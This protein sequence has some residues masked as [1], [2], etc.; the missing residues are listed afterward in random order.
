M[1][2]LLE[3]LLLRPLDMASTTLCIDFPVFCGQ[4]T[5][6]A[7][8]PQA[9]QQAPV[10]TSSP[11]G[12][13]SLSQVDIDLSG[14][15]TKES[16]F[17]LPTERS[18]AT[19]RTSTPE[20][21]PTGLSPPIL[22]PAVVATSFSSVSFFSRAVEAYLLAIWTDVRTQILRSTTLSGSLPEAAYSSWSP[23]FVRLNKQDVEVAISEFSK[24][25]AEPSPLYV[26]ATM[27]ANSVTISGRPDTLSTFSER[28]TAHSS[29]A[30]I[31]VHKTTLDTLYHAPLHV[32]GTREEILAGVVR[33]DIQ[34]PQ[35]ADIHALKRD[36]TRSLVELIVDMVLSQPVNWDLVTLGVLKDLPNDAS[37]VMQRACKTARSYSI[38]REEPSKG[39]REDIAAVAMAVNMPGTPTSLSS[40]KCWN[41][42]LTQSIPEN[43]FKV[44]DYSEAKNPKRQ[45]KA[46]TGNF[47]EGA[48]GFDNHF[49]KIT[50]E[51]ADYVP[52]ATPS[53]NL[54]TFG[55]YIGVATHHYLQNLRDDIDVRFE[56]VLERIPVIFN[57]AQRSLYRCTIPCLISLHGVAPLDADNTIIDRVH[58]TW[59]PSH[60]GQTRMALLNDFGAAG[61]NNT[62]SRARPPASIAQQGVVLKS[63]DFEHQLV[64]MPRNTRIL[65][66]HGRLDQIIPFSFG[67]VR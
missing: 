49:F 6:V 66:V 55:C 23:V 16:I 29:A 39:K 3:L 14:F 2:S 5:A 31:V 13:S 64:D 35:M 22:P 58:T 42:V 57:A 10:D 45:M 4:G 52:N 40:G 46:H 60:D 54:D 7:N 61:S 32:A 26:T 56:S 67:Q 1:S 17:A 65:V 41:K 28:V 8:S 20:L 9:R 63:F 37:G 21:L 15:L 25:I 18:C 12:S 33:R 38:G 62:R 53:F 34:F 36:E 47:I 51:D 27:D 44:S 24:T 43:R 59:D 48:D 30:S 11:S 50:L 19:W